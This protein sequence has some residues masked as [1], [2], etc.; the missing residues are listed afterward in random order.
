MR[1]ATATTDVNPFAQLSLVVEPRLVSTTRW[2][3]VGSPSEIDGLEFAYLAGAPGPQ[4]ETHAGFEIDGVS[5]KV[6]LDFGAGFVDW[7][8]WYTNAG[9]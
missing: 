3:L 7:R 1:Q 2:Y 9:V 8:G 5:V 4:I 6:R